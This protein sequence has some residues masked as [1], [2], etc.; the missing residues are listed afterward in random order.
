MKKNLIYLQIQSIIK[1]QKDKFSIFINSKNISA[2][3][4]II[5]F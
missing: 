1:S 5:Q 3:I 2:I 4:L